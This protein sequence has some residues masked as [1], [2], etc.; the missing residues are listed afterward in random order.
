MTAEL[1]RELRLHSPVGGEP[2][3]FKWPLLETKKYS[4]S[5]EILG[6]IRMVMSQYQELK[7]VINNFI[8]L[9]EIDVRDYDSMKSLCEK[10][11]K[12]AGTISGLW[13]GATRP[14]GENWSAERAD[15]A[16][17]RRI[18]TQS[19]NSAVTDVQLLNKHYEAFS[20]ETYG[21]TSFDRLQMIIDELKPKERDIF[22]DLGS[23]V[24][25]LVVQMAGGS[26][27]KKAVGIEIASVPSQF[28]ET[29]EREFSRWMKWYG[30]KFRPFEL[31]R[32]NFLD[33]KYRDLITKEATIVFI[34][35]YAFTSDLEAAIKR[36][37]LSEMKDGT[38][39]VSTK[40][41]GNPSKPITDRQMNDISS[42]M[43]VSELKPC[44]EPCS[45]T[46]KYVPY[47]LHVINRA[48]LEKYFFD[49]RFP[50]LRTESTSSRRSSSSSKNSSH[51]ESSRESSVSNSREQSVAKN[52]AAAAIAHQSASRTNSQDDGDDVA[53]GPTTRRKWNDYLSQLERNKKQN[54]RTKEKPAPPDSSE[55]PLDSDPDGTPA[56]ARKPGRPPKNGESGGKSPKPRGRPGRPRKSDAERARRKYIRI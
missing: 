12:A 22:V 54:Q 52:P 28:A 40:P 10:F 50:A 44:Q 34:N 39:I 4:G 30:K 31:H 16:L 42:I 51:R 20:S 45:W 18:I 19:Y 14:G 41:Y 9:D 38:R 35:N 15:Q 49:Q 24:G 23:G 33:R 43:D 53:F 32:D 13:K 5:A 48:K 25:Q 36:D 1:G 47:Y 3:V 21:E 8:K 29:M 27:V 6:T 11:S 7:T 46:N 2:L 55:S 37:L 56:R 26:K 17:L